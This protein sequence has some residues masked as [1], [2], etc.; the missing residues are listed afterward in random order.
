MNQRNVDA[1]V[2]RAGFAVA[3]RIAVVAIEAADACVVV[4]ISFV[5]G[6]AF[7]ASDG[8]FVAEHSFDSIVCIAVVDAHAAAVVAAAFAAIL[9]EIEVGPER[10][11]ES[12]I[13]RNLCSNSVE[14]AEHMVAVVDIAVVFAADIVFAVLVEVAQPTFAVVLSVAVGPTEP[15]AVVNYAVELVEQS[16]VI[17][18]VE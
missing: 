18:A 14:H 15:A 5:F 1:V 7:A 8:A 4:A 11:A 3:S 12:S 9:E 2:E 16:I 10:F 13:A 17:A 6:V